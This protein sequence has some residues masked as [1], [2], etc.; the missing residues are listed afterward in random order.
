MNY[1]VSCILQIN[2]V[3]RYLGYKAGK[4]MKWL[5]ARLDELRYTH[6]DLKNLLAKKGIER[7]RATITGWTNDKPV[8]LLGNPQEAE[9]LAEV[10]KWSLPELLVAAG[11]NIGMP[12]EL[13]PE[14]TE[15][16]QVIQR[17][18]DMPK[19]RRLFILTLRQFV[20]VATN[21]SEDDLRNAL[22]DVEAS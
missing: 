20:Q 9:I 4:N 8:S 7:S 1:L 3:A 11:Y 10:L 16:L 5:Q 13:V 6:E 14:I 18:N 21:I 15:L 12:I 2:R 22:L 17:Y 19:R